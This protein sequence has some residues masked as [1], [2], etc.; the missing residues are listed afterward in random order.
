MVYAEGFHHFK[1]EQILCHVGDLNILFMSTAG[2]MSF[3]GM[4]PAAG[5]PFVG[6]SAVVPMVLGSLVLM[7][8]GSLITPKPSQATIDK[9]FPARAKEGSLAMAG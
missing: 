5:Q 6:F 3:M 4:T 9:Y 8:V 1:P 7:V 2:K